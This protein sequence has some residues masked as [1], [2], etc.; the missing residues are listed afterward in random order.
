MRL[1]SG[2]KIWYIWV[3]NQY[4]EV[5]EIIFGDFIA[6][7]MDLKIADFAKLPIHSDLK[8]ILIRKNCAWH[9]T[10]IGSFYDI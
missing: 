8:K 9:V 5:I 7:I 4:T 6:E 3:K 1:Y 10:I 2:V